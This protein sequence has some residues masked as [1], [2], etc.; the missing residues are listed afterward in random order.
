M[1]L[2]EGAM[3]SL[4]KDN[5]PRWSNRKRKVASDYSRVQTILQ[6]SLFIYIHLIN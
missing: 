4:Q 2:S 6:T 3:M 5:L 1:L